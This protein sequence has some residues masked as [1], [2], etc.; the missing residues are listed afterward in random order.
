M[1]LCIKINVANDAILLLFSYGLFFLT[2]P[3][4]PTTHRQTGIHVYILTS[5]Y[6]SINNKHASLPASLCSSMASLSSCD[7]SNSNP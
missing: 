7:I 1:D 6:A 3:A 4:L 5:V 2:L